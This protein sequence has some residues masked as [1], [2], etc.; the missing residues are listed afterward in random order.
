[1]ATAAGGGK[2]KSGLDGKYAN[3][4]GFMW[5]AGFSDFTGISTILPPNGPSCRGYG[6]YATPS[7]YHPGGVNALMCDGSVRF[8]SET[9]NTGNLAAPTMTSG[10]SPYGVWGAMGSRDGG[11]AFSSE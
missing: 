7:S 2:Y 6:M 11:E 4:T 8:I 3:H 9:I 10:P 1:M 5:S